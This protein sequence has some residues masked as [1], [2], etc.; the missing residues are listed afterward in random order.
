M[1]QIQQLLLQPQPFPAKIFVLE[2]CN[3]WILNF[4]SV[5]QFFWRT[6]N[7]TIQEQQTSLDPFG[8]KYLQFFK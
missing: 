2:Y 5:F 3:D 4:A 7:V 8:E 6:M 1:L